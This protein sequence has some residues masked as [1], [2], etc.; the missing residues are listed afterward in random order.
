M[1]SGKLFREFP[2]TGPLRV[3]IEGEGPD[4]SLRTH[5]GPFVRVEMAYGVHGW[6]HGAEERERALLSNPPLRFYGDLLRVGPEPEGVSL[7]YK[8]SLPPEAEVEV[9]VATGDVAV[10]GL[11]KKVRIATGS[12]D[13]VLTDIAGEVRV[14]CGSGDV[15]LQR[16]FGALAIRTGS[17]D[18]VGKDVK[19]D[20]EVETGSG[21]V[22][23]EGV[24][25][26]LHVVT[27]SGDV[28][29]AGRVEEETWRIRTGSGDVDL[30]LLEHF[31]AAVELRTNSGDIACTLPVKI[32]THE[33]G[34][35]RGTV[36]EAP[37]ARILVQTGSGDIILAQG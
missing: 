31:Q 1:R 22:A 30:R 13:V 6:G 8:L 3:E 33:E 20:V 28:R 25:G 35:L 18:I 32:E 34:V 36:G 24:E 23:L 2:V 7:D 29:V 37:R 27:G 9:A 15:S 14:R 11:S 5:E 16:V 26:E 17:G 10:T 19:G 21:D 4:V 12:G